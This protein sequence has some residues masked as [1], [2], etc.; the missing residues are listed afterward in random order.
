M[1]CFLQKPSETLYLPHATLH[2]AWNISPSLSVGDWR[3]YE[4]SFDEWIGSG[5]VYQDRIILKARGQAKS[6]M[7]D[8][9]NQVDEAIDKHRI[10][11]FTRP[12]IGV[13]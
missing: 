9:I 3:L 6:R 12:E 13:Y 4:T 10:V 1:K 2:T 7:M 5:G 11:N 8:I